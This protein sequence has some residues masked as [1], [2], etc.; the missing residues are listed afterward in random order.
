MKRAFLSVFDK[1]GIVAVLT[2]VDNLAGAHTEKKRV[3]WIVGIRR[4]LLIG[5]FGG[6]SLAGVF[7]YTGAGRNLPASKH[8]L[9]MKR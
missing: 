7:K 4:R 8:P 9:A 2:S 5:L 3:E 6:D 1:T